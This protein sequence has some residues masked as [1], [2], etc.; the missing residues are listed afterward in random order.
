MLTSFSAYINITTI[1][2]EIAQVS[3]IGNIHV[4]SLIT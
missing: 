3:T 4:G 1:T 2:A